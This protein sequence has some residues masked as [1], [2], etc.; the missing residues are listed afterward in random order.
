[1]KCLILQKASRNEVFAGMNSLGERGLIRPLLPSS[2]FGNTTKLLDLCATLLR[3]EN[4]SSMDVAVVVIVSTCNHVVLV[5][6][7]MLNNSLKNA[8]SW[9]IV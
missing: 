8:T 3:R 2:I 7:C 1:M 4:S 5:E 6:I 9:I